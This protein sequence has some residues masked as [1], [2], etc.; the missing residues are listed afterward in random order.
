[1]KLEKNRVAATIVVAVSALLATAAI[2]GC[3]TRIYR[4]TNS[5]P[6][7]PPAKPASPTQQV[8]QPQAPL[9]PG[10]VGSLAQVPW[11][12]IGPGWALADYTTGNHQVP[13][14]VTL[15]MID[16]E[17]GRYQLYHWPAT[18]LPWTLIAWSG[19]KTRVLFTGESTRSLHELTIATGRVTSFTLPADVTYVLGYTRPDG[20]NILAAQD[21][22][23]RYSLTG[24]VQGRLSVD[25]AAFDTIVSSPDGLTEIVNGSSGVELVSNAGKIVRQLPVPG[26][27]PGI[28]CTPVRWWN[29]SDVLVMCRPNNG[30]FEPQLWA[31]PVN[32]TTPM[33]VTQARTGTGPDLGDFNAWQLPSG[34]YLDALGACGT[35]FIGKQ[36][37]NGAVQVVNVPGSSGDNEAVEASASRLL[38][39]ETSGCVPS[40]SLVWFDPATNTVQQVL[41][42][43][44]NAIGVYS[45]VAFDADGEQPQG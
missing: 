4:G 30:T 11:G 34:L 33:P 10:Q 43:E 13:A 25:N 27:N 35:T 16:P 38:V 32:G 45:V 40:S 39:R 8:E 2:A 29:A 41:T 42:A 28:G 6:S 1:M 3:G 24:V 22:I 12:Q 36:S 26:T 37:A 19:D 17:G 7:G 14:P 5:P 31:V 18:A 23:V 20:E 9:G 15:Y 44:P 21:G